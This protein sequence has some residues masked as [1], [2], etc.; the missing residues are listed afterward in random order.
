MELMQLRMLLTP[1][2]EVLV[3]YARRMRML[4]DKGSQPSKKLA[5]GA[6]ARRVSGPNESINLYV[7]PQLTEMFRQLCPDVKV[8][9][10]CA[11]SDV[12]LLAL[13]LSVIVNTRQPEEQ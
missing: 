13:A 5:R 4:H 6:V 12:L 10:T 2:G 7:I 3:E 11:H 1:A 9:V 8:E